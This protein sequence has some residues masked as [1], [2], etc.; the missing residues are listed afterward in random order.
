MQEN[1]H[2]NKKNHREFSLSSFA[3]DNGTSIFILT[4]MLMLFGIRSYNAMP[5]E[6]YPEISFPEIFVNTVYF[7]NSASDIE[8]L[9]TRPIEK[10]LASISEIKNITSS[11]LQDYSLITAEFDTDVDLDE[12]ADKVRRSSR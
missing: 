10:E 6:S 9:V 2:T 1:S 5:K 11:S 8:N 12:A 3:V 7:G 4:F